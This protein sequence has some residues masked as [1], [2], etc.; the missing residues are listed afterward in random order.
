M[1]EE[2]KWSLML[3]KGL[4]GIHP[5]LIP[6]EHKSRSELLKGIIKNAEQNMRFI[7]EASASADVQAAQFQED[8]RNT[9]TIKDYATEKTS[10]TIARAAEYA[11]QKSRHTK[12][13]IFVSPENVFPEQYGAHPRELR[14]TIVN[15]REAFAKV[16]MEKH[17]KGAEEAKK[18][19]EQHI[20]A[21]FDIGHANMWKKYYE[22]DPHK[23][24]EENDKAFNKW[25]IGQVRELFDKKIIGHI[26][27]S[28]N[29][30]WDDE[31]VT[32]GQGIAP[33][34]EFVEELRKAGIKD[35]IVEPAH[36][37]YRALLGGWREF[38]SSI[39]GLAA[40][41]RERWSDIEYSY[42]GRTAPPYF[43]YGESAPDPEQ[44]SLWTGSR[45]E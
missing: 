9:V 2:E 6:P 17:H 40:P 15:S 35:V 21:T 37:D 43:L 10:D 27:I 38:G 13:P 32:P 11:F 42:F 36:Q 1:P 22:G 34:K 31:H 19:A 29:F 30:G 26:H 3:E 18:L 23:T 33:I 45:L 39:Y 16:L 20:K 12:E 8:M 7:H 14:D 28:D 24:P 41:A 25:L 4:P 44:W 5:S